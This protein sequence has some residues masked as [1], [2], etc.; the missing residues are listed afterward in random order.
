MTPEVL[1][2]L[3]ALCLIALSV[4]AFFIRSLVVSISEVDKN[5]AVLVANN[6]HLD[7][8]IV[9]AEDRLKNLEVSDNLI[10]ES[11][12]DFRSAISSRVQ[13]LEIKLENVEIK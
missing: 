8:R 13:F 5:V 9:T 2:I 3:G 6:K 7:L 4:N 11:L 12:H 10:R 1:Q